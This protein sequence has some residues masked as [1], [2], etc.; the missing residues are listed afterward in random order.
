MWRGV[1]LVVVLVAAAVATACD[2]GSGDGDVATPSRNLQLTPIDEASGCDFR[3]VTPPATD[4]SPLVE[5]SLEEAEELLGFE[6]RVPE[7][8]PAD[9]V[10]ERPRLYRSTLCPDQILA[11]T[12]DLVYTGPGYTILLTQSVSA[13]HSDAFQETVEVNGV[14]GRV[15]RS[16]EGL[17]VGWTIGDRQYSA[18]LSL[19]GGQLAEERFLEILESIP[20]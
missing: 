18:F 20:E 13:S 16:G 6:P 3:S 2:G 9:V 7:D 11:D 10:M 1:A 4:V 5:V 14:E 19:D 15:R 8:L 17:S 12:L